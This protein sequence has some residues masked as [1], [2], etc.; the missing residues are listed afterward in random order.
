MFDINKK[1]KKVRGKLDIWS[2]LSQMNA[3]HEHFGIVAAFL[4]GSNW[5]VEIDIAPPDSDMN[6]K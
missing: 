1:P 2:L 3:Q 4:Y 6:K 5:E